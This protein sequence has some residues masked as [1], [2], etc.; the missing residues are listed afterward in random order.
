LQVFLQTAN[1][2]ASDS[3]GE[4]RKTGKKDRSGFTVRSWG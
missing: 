2:D 4:S 1:D 3:S